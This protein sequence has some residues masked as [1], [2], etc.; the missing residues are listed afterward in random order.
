VDFC[1]LSPIAGLERYSTLSKTHLLLSQIRDPRYW[2]FYNRRHKAGDFI[3]LDNG[4]YE[5]QLDRVRL[6]EC[7]KLVHPHVVALPDR[8][9]ED[10]KASHRSSINFLESY[11]YEFDNLE[12]LYI[13]Q[14]SPGDIVGFVESLFKA[15]DDERISWIGL[16]RALSY[17]I[18][19][20]LLMRVRVAEQIRKRNSRVKIHALGM[21]KGSLEELRQLRSSGCVT[22]ID[23]NAPVWRG[24]CGYSLIR[25]ENFKFIN[26]PEYPVNYEAEFVEKPL[27]GREPIHELIL[28]NLEACGVNTNIPIRPRSS[29]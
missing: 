19:S 28:E 24:W 20:D 22:S 7:I 13:P 8:L 1:I 25:V 2:E 10:W 23:S 17:S 3:I 12:W 21:V 18:T 11:Y 29:T 16:P 4:A 5:G 26:W 15:L 9:G 14:A 6:I 27:G